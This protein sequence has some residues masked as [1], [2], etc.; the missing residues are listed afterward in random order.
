[1]TSK[2]QIEMSMAASHLEAPIIDLLRAWK[3]I[4]PGEEVT[5]EIQA[6]IPLIIHINKQEANGYRL[7]S[8]G[9]KL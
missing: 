1:M 7:N 3:V 6:M 5:V 8:K 9:Q 2:R 4:A